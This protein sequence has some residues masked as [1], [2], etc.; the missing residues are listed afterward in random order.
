MNVTHQVELADGAIVGASGHFGYQDRLY[1][2]TGS[3]QGRVQLQLAAAPSL[4]IGDTE[5]RPIQG[6]LIR[7]DQGV[8]RP[9]T[10][11]IDAEGHR[12]IGTGFGISQLFTELMPRVSTNTVGQ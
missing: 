2:V 12:Y 8:V 9:G 6:D 3:D 4:K 5:L 7:F 1:E 11:L 10:E